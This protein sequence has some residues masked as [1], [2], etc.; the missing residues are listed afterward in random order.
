MSGN[1]RETL[2]EV[3]EWSGDHP[4][5]PRVVVMHSRMSGSGREALLDV[6]D[7]LPHVREWSEDS[8]G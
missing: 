2:R 7:A 4:G 8:L 5:C 6:R 3:R 1:S